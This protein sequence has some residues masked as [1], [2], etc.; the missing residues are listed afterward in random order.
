MSVSKPIVA[1]VGRQNVGKSALL[2]RLVEVFETGERGI[3]ASSYAE[4]VGAPA[5][6]ARS[7]FS[8]LSALRGDRGAKSVLEAHDAELAQVPFP[9]GATDLDTPEDYQQF[10]G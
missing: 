10:I 7:H 1:I 2:N 4:T 9:D 8:E 5:L 3:V 6:F